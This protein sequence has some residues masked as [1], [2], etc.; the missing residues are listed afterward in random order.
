VGSRKQNFRKSDYL[1]AQ[2]YERL[3]RDI[4]ESQA[5]YNCFQVAGPDV[6]REGILKV[7]MQY[8]LYFLLGF[9]TS[10]ATRMKLRWVADPT[11]KESLTQDPPSLDSEERA[12]EAMQGLGPLTRHEIHVLRYLNKKGCSVTPKLL[13]WDHLCQPDSMPV[14][15]GYLAFLLMERVPGETLDLHFWHYEFPKREKIRA[16][17]RRALT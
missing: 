14:P 15:G 5:V 1:E 4:S 10:K 7:R 17:F 2:Q 11:H 12:K 16:A 3:E 9:P 6:G 8:G 13:T